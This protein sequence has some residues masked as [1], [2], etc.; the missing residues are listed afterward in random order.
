MKSFNACV[1]LFV[2]NFQLLWADSGLCTY[3]HSPFHQYH[4]IPCTSVTSPIDSLELQVS[5]ERSNIF[6][7][8]ENNA[9]DDEVAIVDGE[10]D[11]QLIKLEKKLSRFVFGVELSQVGH[12]GGNWDSDI[13]SWHS[14]FNFVNWDRENY[15]RDDLK[16][17]YSSPDEQLAIT[18]SHTL[19][20]ASYH[21][22]LVLTGKT[23]GFNAIRLGHTKSSRNP[24]VASSTTWLNIQSSSYSLSTAHS[25]TVSGGISYA[26]KEGVLADVQEPWLYFGS[27]NYEYG[28]YQ[29]LKL[30]FGISGSTA[31]Y[32]SESAVLGKASSQVTAAIAWVVTEGNQLSI[33][34][35]E[36]VQIAA[37][38]DVTFQIT[39]RYK[40]H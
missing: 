4:Y 28:W 25:M 32:D 2:F 38:P 18:A 17:K 27:L 23:L 19:Q 29:R 36:D 26:E 39:Y 12:S 21:V 40:S 33:A 30:L 7:Y 9:L 37:S 10:V 1:V 13:E 11:R 5:S 14:T 24:L 8:D 6:Y 3:N 20:R 35:T 31:H 16:Y 15:P 34:M 22:G